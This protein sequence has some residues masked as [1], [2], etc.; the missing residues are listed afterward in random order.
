MSSVAISSS[1]LTGVEQVQQC[2]SEN[3]LHVAGV[4]CQAAEQR[5]VL[6]FNI[7]WDTSNEVRMGSLILRSVLWSARYCTFGRM[8]SFSLRRSTIVFAV[9]TPLNGGQRSGSV[10]PAS[11]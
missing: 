2:D 3:K 8:S 10:K 6:Q 7:K 1:T 5:H 9:G 4:C 11:L